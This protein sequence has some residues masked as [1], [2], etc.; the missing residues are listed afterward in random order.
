MKK[1]NNM[2]ADGRDVSEQEANE[3]DALA[4]DFPEDVL[5]KKNLPEISKLTPEIQ[6]EDK[7][8]GVEKA[9]KQL[10]EYSEGTPKRG[11]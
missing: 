3:I 7:S 10:D 11:E 8:D 4:E 5:P 2:T 9:L 1:Y 6:L